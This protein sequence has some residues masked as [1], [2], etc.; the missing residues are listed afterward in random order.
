VYLDSDG[1]FLPREHRRPFKGFKRSQFVK[2][3]WSLKLIGAWQ[4][5][6]GHASV[7]RAEY[8][9]LRGCWLRTGENTS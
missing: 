2:P 7:A 1:L 9:A 3:A 4:V 6:F 5:F 8:V